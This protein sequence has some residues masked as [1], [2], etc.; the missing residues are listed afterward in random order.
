VD[1]VALAVTDGMLHF[2]LAL[3]YEVFGVAPAGVAAPWYDV[4]VCGPDAVRVGR[5]G[6]EP[7]HGLDQLPRADTVIVP[8]WADV[9][10]APPADLVEVGWVGAPRRVLE[11]RPTRDELARSADS[12]VAVSPAAGRS[13]C[14]PGRAE[15]PRRPTAG[16]GVDCRTARPGC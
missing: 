9:D 7:N 3:A 10:Q 4:V 16:V 15:P 12:T 5:D 6:L 1:T 2:E 14:R 11:S 13:C 8:G